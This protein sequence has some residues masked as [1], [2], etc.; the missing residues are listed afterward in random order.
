MAFDIALL[1]IDGVGK[2]SISRALADA[3]RERGL[4]VTV[5]SWRDYFRRG[6]PAVL[7]SAYTTIFRSAYSAYVDPEGNS[8]SPLLPAREE[9][10]LREAGESL[11]MD[12]EAVPLTLDRG[13]PGTFLAVGLMEIAA[14]IL[15]REL[16][17]APALAR[18]EVVV[19][20]GHGLK[21][22]VKV[23]AVAANFLGGDDRVA[24]YLS[25]ARDLL[26]QWAAPDVSVFVS[27]DPFLAY[28]WRKRQRG[29]I[30]RGERLDRDGSPAESAFVELQTVI[31]RE[32]AG[33][34]AA[35]RWP[36]VLMSD[37]PRE[38]NVTEAVATVLGALADR[39]LLPAGART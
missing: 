23:A 35:E 33:V 30:G 31:Q 17:I 38:E 12:D 19:Q 18:G 15:E 27:G 22:A 21:N 2:S 20:E 37:R 36:S 25:S 10:F 28:R 16:V 11:P 34:A 6:S 7:S 4:A 1:G 32:L 3:L 8:G 29:R 14:R 13:R 5:T 26:G 24:G 39:G 9:D